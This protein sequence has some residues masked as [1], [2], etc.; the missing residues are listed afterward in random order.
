M[1]IF[2]AFSKSL[3]TWNSNLLLNVKFQ[4]VCIS[5]RNLTVLQFS[6]WKCIWEKTF[7]CEAYPFIC[8]TKI[9]INRNSNQSYRIT[10]RLLHRPSL[11]YTIDKVPTKAPH[12]WL[13][14]QVQIKKNKQTNKIGNEKKNHKKIKF[15]NLTLDKQVSNK[16]GLNYLN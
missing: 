2:T 10:Q 13:G 16:V 7:T 12:N 6:A 3:M 11:F 1:C 9:L 8:L 15:E 4:V 14:P 5:S